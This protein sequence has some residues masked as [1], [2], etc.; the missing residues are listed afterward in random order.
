MPSAGPWVAVSAGEAASCNP[1]CSS[2]IPAMRRDRA[3]AS[4]AA[5]QS[6]TAPSAAGGRRA[7]RHHLGERARRCRGCLHIMSRRA[8]ST[9]APQHRCRGAAAHTRE[10]QG[11]HADPA[12]AAHL[13]PAPLNRAGSAAAAA[14]RA[15][16][17]RP[18]RPP[19][20]RTARV[21]TAPAASAS[22]PMAAAAAAAT[23]QW[24]RASHLRCTQASGGAG[25]VSSKCDPGCTGTALSRW[26][27]PG[28][29]AGGSPCAAS[30]SWP[31]CTMPRSD[32]RS[33]TPCRSPGARRTGK[34]W[35]GCVRCTRSL[36]VG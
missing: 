5:R 28:R 18:C 16:A 11:R 6:A 35:S 29:A 8:C 26:L 2:C 36:L 32:A 4:A 21:A 15:A 12:A 20:G 9:A 25:V 34:A 33:Y 7:A 22:S 31:C 14:A 30:C 17:A 19:P 1:H 10:R 3:A 23:A 24:G 27:V 13:H